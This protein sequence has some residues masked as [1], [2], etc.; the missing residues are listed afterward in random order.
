MTSNPTRTRTLPLVL[1][2]GMITAFDAMAVD[3]YLPS[4]RDIG[5]TL[6]TD[7]GTLQ[8][9]LAVFVGGAAIGQLSMGP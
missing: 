5:R 2:L 4:M 8:V 1:V 6:G 3:M 9:S 7:P